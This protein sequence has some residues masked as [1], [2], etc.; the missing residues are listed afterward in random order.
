MIGPMARKEIVPPFRLGLTQTKRFNC[1]QMTASR[2]VATVDGSISFA[3]PALGLPGKRTH[4]S[5]F[6]YLKSSLL[7]QPQTQSISILH[8]AC[9]E[10]STDQGAVRFQDPSDQ[11]TPHPIGFKDTRELENKFMALK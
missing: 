9:L 11:I 7:N 4:Q 5:E 1:S 10:Q 6:K 8:L 3:L 2:E